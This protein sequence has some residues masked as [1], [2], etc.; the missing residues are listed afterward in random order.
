MPTTLGKELI[1][2]NLP[3]ELR[4]N[5]GELTKKNIMSLYNKLATDHPNLYRQVSVAL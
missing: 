3:R 5:V 4:D 2:Q 1:R